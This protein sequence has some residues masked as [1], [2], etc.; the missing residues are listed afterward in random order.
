MLYNPFVY[1]FNKLNT[2]KNFFDLFKLPK[3]KFCEEK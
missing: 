2:Q 1:I 3:K